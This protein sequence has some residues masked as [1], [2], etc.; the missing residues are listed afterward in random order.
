MIMQK[1]AFTIILA[2]V[3]LTAHSVDVTVDCG[4]VQNDVATFWNCVGMSVASDGC[5]RLLEPDWKQHFALL[6]SVPHSGQTYCRMHHLLSLVDG[7]DLQ[8]ENPEY[9]WTLLDSLF[10][11]FHA[12]GLT[13][14]LELMGSPGGQ[15]PPENYVDPAQNEAWRKLVKALAEHYITVYG[16]EAV[17]EW[18][19]E[20][21]NEVGTGFWPIDPIFYTRFYDY[22]VAGIKEADSSLRVGGPASKEEWEIFF[23][24]IVHGENYVTGEIGTPIDFISVHLKDWDSPLTLTELAYHDSL[25]RTWPSLADKPFFNDEADPN[26]GFSSAKYFRPLPEYAAFVANQVIQKQLRIIDSAGIN[27]PILSNDNG[28]IGGWGWRTQFVRFGYPMPDRF[29]HHIKADSFTYVKKP[30]HTVM[31]LLSLLGNKQIAVNRLSETTWDKGVLASMRDDNHVAVLFSNRKAGADEI[32]LTIN[33]V[34]FIDA[35]LVHYRIDSTHTNPFS[36]WQSDSIPPVDILD[37]LRKECELSYL[38]PVE[39]VTVSNGSF[40][41]AFSMP[42]NA[43]SLVVLTARPAEQPAEIGNIRVSEFNGVYGPEYLVQWDGLDSRKIL[44]YEV[45]YSETESGSY[46]RVNDADILSTAFVHPGASEQGYYTVRAVDYWG[47]RSYGTGA[48]RSNVHSTGPLL[49]KNSGKTCVI[50]SG[51]HSGRVQL[52]RGIQGFCIFDVKGRA[53]FE[54]RRDAVD[55]PVEVPVDMAKLG[56]GIH[57]VRYK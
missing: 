55:A 4:E 1:A 15:F 40:I 43:V 7:T 37:S 34:P 14:F 48:I 35:A 56:Q 36:I 47:R 50:Q 13:P 31:V 12:S 27:Y 28:F 6:G 25:A 44:T 10:S 32:E 19:F 9:D 11:I 38:Q 51:A 8:G 21:W 16:L 53:V 2:G 54:Y 57:I 52:D 46:E 39:H 5:E 29:N 18:Y 26:I 23:N 30:V 33:N 17:Q 45:M 49:S 24:H 3:F 42:E 22:S 41:H 20:V